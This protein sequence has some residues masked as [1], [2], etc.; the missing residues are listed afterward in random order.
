MPRVKSGAL[1]VNLGAPETPTTEGIRRFLA[2]FLSDPRVVDYPPFL[3][4]PILRGVVLNLRPRRTAPAYAAIRRSEAGESP[5]RYYTRRQ[6]ERLQERLGPRILVDWAMRYGLPS[7]GER[8]SS[9]EERG[10]TRILVAPLYPQYSRTTTASVEDAVAAYGAPAAAIALAGDFHANPKYIAALAA[11]ARRR[12][13]ELDFAPERIVLSFH[14]L[15]ERHIARGDPYKHQCEETARRLRAAMSWSEDFAPLAWQS[16]FGPERWLGPPTFGVVERL[17]RAGVRRLAVMAPGFV[18]D[19]FETL[20]ELGVRT[21]RR[22]LAAGGSRFD[23]FPCLNDGDG[24]IELLADLVR[25]G[26]FG[27]G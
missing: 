3:W 21:R 16:R 7:I 19:C 4:R 25:R 11:D 15:P 12:L 26:A 24:M 17:A 23:V 20:D 22:F 13:S 5:L 18:A 6:A 9:L 2:E 1:L 14:S 8:L 27:D 10:A